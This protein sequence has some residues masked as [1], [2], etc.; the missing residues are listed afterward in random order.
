MP[1]F[2]AAPISFEDRPRRP[3]R[4]EEAVLRR[5]IFGARF[6]SAVACQMP[7]VPGRISF[8]ED[9]LRNK[10]FYEYDLPLLFGHQNSFPAEML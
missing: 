3:L 4:I 5:L 1:I 10:S 7:I 8:E 9:P 6:P 2:G